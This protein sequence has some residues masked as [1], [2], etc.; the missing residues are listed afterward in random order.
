MSFACYISLTL[1][2]DNYR[3]SV[4]RLGIQCNR[5]NDNVK[6]AWHWKRQSL[7]QL[8]TTL[9][10]DTTIDNKQDHLLTKCSC[11]MLLP[12]ICLSACLSCVLSYQIWMKMTEWTGQ[13]EMTY[14]SMTGGGFICGG[15]PTIGCVVIVKQ[16]GK[17]KITTEIV[18]SSLVQQ[19]HFPLTLWVFLPK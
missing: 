13:N 14:I 19:Q 6:F 4:I 1:V 15:R 18:T 10:Q 17:V 7:H 11:Q 9:L 5:S 3:E 8:L 16:L 12:F 2:L